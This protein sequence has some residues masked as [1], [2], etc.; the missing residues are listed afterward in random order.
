[1]EQRIMFLRSELTETKASMSVIMHTVQMRHRRWFSKDAE[2]KEVTITLQF[3]SMKLWKE[4]I[5]TEVNTVCKKVNTWTRESITKVDRQ[6]ITESLALE[7]KDKDQVTWQLQDWY[8][9]SQ[10]Q[11]TRM[12]KKNPVANLR[13]KQKKLFG[14]TFRPWTMKKKGKT[15]ILEIWVMYLLRKHQHKVAR[16]HCK[17][18]HRRRK[19]LDTSKT[20]NLRKQLELT[21]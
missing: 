4:R 9:T 6:S 15:Q 19:Q 2:S 17:P 11:S 12:T 10:T 18:I 8:C 13:Q 21:S 5:C 20:S 1:M 3:I 16:K 14:I 7:I